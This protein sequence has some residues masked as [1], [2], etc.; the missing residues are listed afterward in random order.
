LTSGNARKKN[1]NTQHRLKA[2]ALVRRFWDGNTE[3]TFMD[4]EYIDDIDGLPIRA[5][6]ALRRAGTTTIGELRKMTDCQLA[7]VRNLGAKYIAA[8]DT[9]VPGRIRTYE[10]ETEEREAHRTK[11]TIERDARRIMRFMEDHN[12]TLSELMKSS[13]RLPGKRRARQLLMEYCAISPERTAEVLRHFEAMGD[14]ADAFCKRLKQHIFPR[15]NHPTKQQN[16]KN[17][18][19]SPYGNIQS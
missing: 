3:V 17:S 2:V 16:R 5:R 1:K 14:T 9:A 11:Y 8:I 13:C 18:G 12:M 7:N 19:G 6:N 10:G 4:T 15:Y